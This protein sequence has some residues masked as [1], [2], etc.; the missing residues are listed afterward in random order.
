MLQHL[1]N[2]SNKIEE[3]KVE[4][5]FLSQ[6][7]QPELHQFLTSLKSSFSP[8]KDLDTPTIELPV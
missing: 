7:S 2:F 3:K 6:S 5:K 4:I 8:K 1:N